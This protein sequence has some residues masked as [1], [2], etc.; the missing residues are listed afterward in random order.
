MPFSDYKCA[1][2]T[3]ASSGIGRA[4]VIRLAK[5]NIKLHALARDGE[6]LQELALKTGCHIEVL[7][8]R[9]TQALVQLTNAHEFDILINCAGIDTP[10]KFLD[11][12]PEDIDSQIDVNLRSVLHLSRLIVPGMVKRNCGH[13]INVTSIA[14]NYNFGGN[15]IYHTVKAG[16]AMLTSQLRLDCFGAQVRVTELCP[17]RVATDIFAHVHGDSPQTHARFLEG[18]ELP[19]PEDIAETIAFVI[20]APRAVNFGHIEITPTLQVLGGLQTT[21][22]ADAR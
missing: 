17:G 14:G 16:M 19:Q 20:N 11:A 21:K 7:D 8:V 15:S 22:P 12:T 18:F 4:C 1:L 2:V 3:G 9:D 10:R 6:K 5:E 13:V